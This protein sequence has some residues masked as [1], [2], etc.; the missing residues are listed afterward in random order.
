MSIFERWRGQRSVTCW[1]VRRVCMIHCTKRQKEWDQRAGTGVAEN[2][3]GTYNWQ[4]Q[5]YNNP[6]FQRMSFSRTTNTN[7]AINKTRRKSDIK[8]AQIDESKRKVEAE[9]W[10]RNVIK[11]RLQR[12]S[13]GKQLDIM[14]QMTQAFSCLTTM[15]ISY[16][17]FLLSVGAL[18]HSE[19]QV[20][21]GSIF[22]PATGSSKPAV[23]VFTLHKKN[24]RNNRVKHFKYQGSTSSIERS[25]PKLR[26]D[27]INQIRSL[28]KW[29]PYWKANTWQTKQKQNWTIQLFSQLC[30]KC[31]RR[32]LKT[33]TYK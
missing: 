17:L 11:R 25:M 5:T 7:N 15:A 6:I 16:L 28:G 27:A 24:H 19:R 10:M 23:D 20:P 2:K 3:I 8:C 32:T 12:V 29:H 14:P 30:C 33:K 4:K 21:L 1:S 31:Q 26:T 22:K 18:I 13:V 9:D